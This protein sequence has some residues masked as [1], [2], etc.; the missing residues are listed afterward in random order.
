MLCVI[1]LASSPKVE[2]SNGIW[3]IL[4]GKK[5]IFKLKEIWK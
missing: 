3:A 4:A 5:M 2:L 1:M